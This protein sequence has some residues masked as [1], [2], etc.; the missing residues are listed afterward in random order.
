MQDISSNIQINEEHYDVVYSQTNLDAIIAKLRDLDNFL[1]D[2]TITDTSWHGMYLNNFADRIK[3]KKVFEIGSGDGLNALI[4]AKLGAKV[5]AND[6]STQS[7][8]I[9]REISSEL[10]IKNIE[11]VNG[12]FRNVTVDEGSFDFVI[13]KAFLHH[14]THELE[15]EFL[16]R[17][18]RL[19]KP[20][21]EA[22]FF[23]PA[24]NS[25]NL[26]KLR[27]M[28][29]VPGRPSI[30]NKRVFA[31]WKK[32]D[33]HP[34]RDNSADHFV[35]SGKRFFAKVEV[36]PIGTIE[37]FCRLIPEGPFNRKYRRWAHRV[38]PRLPFWI[39]HKAAR[40]QT[41][42]YQQPFK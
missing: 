23:E 16:A 21:G 33:P 24:T 20:D 19:L 26:D 37:R 4:M 1:A 42:I 40:S 34:D 5:T 22:R 25:Q 36:I 39:R 41:I 18:A 3:G 27:W 9:I 28:V 7:G 35:E 29:P 38:Q 6:I 30:L 31:E 2:A 15:T 11:F 12:D 14:L 13:G 10:A 8:R 17:A 32:N